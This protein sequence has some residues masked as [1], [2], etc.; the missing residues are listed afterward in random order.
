MTLKQ[1]VTKN[2]AEILSVLKTAAFVSSEEVSNA[3]VHLKIALVTI[4]NPH[5]TCRNKRENRR[6]VNLPRAKASIVAGY[7]TTLKLAGERK[8]MWKQ[9]TR[10]HNI[11]ADGWAGASIPHPHPNPH[12]TL[13][14]ILKII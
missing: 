1:A 10:G 8:S 3:S 14:N 2:F 9:V 6:V 4:A 11:V 5:K 12:P 13:T 7:S